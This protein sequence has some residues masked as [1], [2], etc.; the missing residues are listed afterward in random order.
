MFSLESEHGGEKK[1]KEASHQTAAKQGPEQFL[2]AL[3]Q[4]EES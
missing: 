3:T 2:S 4:M 1:K